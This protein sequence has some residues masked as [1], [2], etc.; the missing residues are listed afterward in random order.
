MVHQISEQ[1]F[2]CKVT[3][4]RMKQDHMSLHLL[5]VP[6]IICFSYHT[7]MIALLHVTEPWW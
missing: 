1:I 2:I 5:L 7:F 4:Y 6:L 3:L